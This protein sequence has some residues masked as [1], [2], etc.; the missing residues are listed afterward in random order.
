MQLK[1][2]TSAATL[3]LVSGSAMTLGTTDSGGDQTL[4][5]VNDLKFKQ[6]TSGADVTGTSTAGGI[7]GGSIDAAGNVTLNA[8]KEIVFDTITAGQNANLLAGTSL[9]GAK[10][11]ATQGNINATAGTDL[12]IQ[13]IT[14]GGSVDLKAGSSLTLGTVTVGKD[15]GLIG[16]S[17]IKFIDLAAGDGI[18]VQSTGGSVTGTRLTAPHANL[19]ADKAIT[20]QDA[21]IASR[22]NLAAAD[23]DAHVT[24]TAT[25]PADPFAMIVTG[26]KNGRA[27]K[28]RLSIDAPI[29]LI[30]NRLVA[31]R[32]QVD[33]TANKV[34]IQ[35][36]NISQI[37]SLNTP[38]T[39]LLLDNVTPKLSNVDFQLTQPTY[40]FYLR[41]DHRQIMT[42]AFVTHYRRGYQTNQVSNYT[43]P[44]R[45]G[46]TP[47]GGESAV[48]HTFRTL[49]SSL[50]YPGS[51]VSGVINSNEPLADQRIWAD[52]MLLGAPTSGVAL[53]LGQ[54]STQ[55]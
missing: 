4:D 28:L 36:G 54:P 2:V 10:L 12:A 24:Q 16:V 53:N 21:E 17:D 23:I 40:N 8:F 51:G 7:R 3:G 39:S 30:F 20:V 44:H 11:T 35:A 38:S 55:K 14:A 45:Y 19:S 25:P 43:S 18:T 5:A 49:R 32:A 26:Y 15:L 1:Q 47:Y 22:L 48:R 37:L 46:R 33:T 6:L 50:N 31:A 9:T 29:G 13:K 52:S 41:E 27:Q 34:N 42:N